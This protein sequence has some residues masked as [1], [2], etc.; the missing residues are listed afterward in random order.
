MAEH[1]RQH[2]LRDDC[3]DGVQRI[4]LATLGVHQEAD[5]QGREENT[6]QAG[7]RRTANRGG[8]VAPRQRGKGNR[9]L[10]RGR[11]RAEVEEAGMNARGQQGRHGHTKDKT[12]QRK[13]HEGAGENQQMQFPVSQ[14][15][16]H[17]F[18]RE[19]GTVHEEQEGNGRRGQ[20]PEKGLV[21]AGTGKHRRQHDHGH[22]HQQEAIDFQTLQPRHPF[23]LLVR[24]EKAL[25]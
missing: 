13:Q 5:Q 14:P 6:E 10:Y 17:R 19:L 23:R 9:R 3:A 8:N 24:E 1:E 11:Q 4:R 22:Q 20:M 7:C 18:A 25:R 15:G 16:Q 12:K 21:N 2:Q